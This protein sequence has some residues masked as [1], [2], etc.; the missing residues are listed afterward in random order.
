MHLFSLLSLAF[1]AAGCVSPVAASDEA[2]EERWAREIV[3]QVVVGDAVW[4]ATPQRSNVLALYHYF[5]TATGA[6]ID[7]IVPFVERAFR[8]DC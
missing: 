7:A 5:A 4:L 2:R 6:L 1:L 8:D 3:P